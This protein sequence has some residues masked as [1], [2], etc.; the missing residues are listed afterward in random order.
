L[1]FKESSDEQLKPF[2]GFLLLR[3]LS[4]SSPSKKQQRK[5]RLRKV[6]YRRLG[7]APHRRFGLIYNFPR[8]FLT[9]G[10]ECLRP[11]SS[12]SY[13]PW[14][15]F[16]IV[17]RFKR[18]ISK[19][20]AGKAF[21]LLSVNAHEPIRGERRQPAAY[22]C[23]LSDLRQRAINV[24]IFVIDFTDFALVPLTPPL[25]PARRCVYN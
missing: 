7:F 16:I 18:L 4:L 8:A 11:T 15:E 25:H 23:Y 19:V 12:A 6:I 3:T 5:S 21:C 20:K 14:R 24:N 13:V 10:L 9:T 17:A 22:A 2:S 1:Q